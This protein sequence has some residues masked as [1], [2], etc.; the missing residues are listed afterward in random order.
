MFALS[1]SRLRPARWPRQA[2]ALFVG[3]LLVGWSCVSWAAD[4]GTAVLT[5]PETLARVLESSPELAVYPYEI[6]AAEARTLQAELRPNP[7]LSVEVENVLGSGTVTGVDAMETTLALSQVIEM[8]NKRNLRRDV[9][10][11]QRQVV[12]RDYELARLDVLTA[13]AKRYLEVAQ[14]QRLLE[15]SEQVVEWTSSAQSAAKKR[16]D[17]GGVSRAE[18]GR[19]RTDAMQAALAVSNLEM[20]LANARRRLAS[21]WGESEPDFSIVHAELF[22]LAEMPEFALI[23]AQLEQAPQL[24]RF[25]T[26]GRLKQAQLDLA[27]AS[28]RQDI[29]VGAGFK[30]LRETSDVGMVLQFSMPLG[31]NDQNQGNIQA[32]REDLAKLDLEEE[33]TRVKIFAELRNAYAQLEQSRVQVAVLRDEILPEAMETLSLIQE[34]YGVGR[35]SYLELLQA[36]QQVLA[37]ENEAVVAATEFHQILITL[38][39]LTGQPLTESGKSVAGPTNATAV[40]AGYRLPYLDGSSGAGR[41]SPKDESR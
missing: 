7:V 10:S 31:V 6:R 11:W 41:T 28:G 21:L 18:L 35:F 39:S 33:A 3:S 29:E 37:V 5:L 24:Q 2:G 36:R 34:G 12:E 16:F 30:H 26:Q 13:A 20:R 8:G 27:V 25:L 4:R 23:R 15:F 14:A 22:S 38:E 9:G 40:S 32:A 17:A 1:C 19:V